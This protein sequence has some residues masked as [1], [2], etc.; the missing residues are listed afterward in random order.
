MIYFCKRFLMFLQFQ[1]VFFPTLEEV[2][3]NFLQS[4]V[5]MWTTQFHIH[6]LNKKAEEYKSFICYTTYT[7]LLLVSTPSY[8]L[9]HFR[10]KHGSFITWFICCQLKKKKKNRQ[11]P[12]FDISGWLYPVLPRG[13]GSCYPHPSIHPR[14]WAVGAACG[15]ADRL[16]TDSPG[17]FYSQPGAAWDEKELKEWDQAGEGHKL[18]RV[19]HLPSPT[20][21]FSS[22]L[23]EHHR[24]LCPRGK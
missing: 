17:S 24:D 13:A 15:G 14:G 1:V 11:T 4:S 2:T 22:F 19:F 21:A 10:R 18:Q 20:A 23:G 9:M 12:L 5:N 6:R 16:W 3:C 7:H 8:C